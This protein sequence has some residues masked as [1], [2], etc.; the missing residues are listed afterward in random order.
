[1]GTEAVRHLMTQP[2]RYDVFKGARFSMELQ[3]PE[4]DRRITIKRTDQ[5]AQ[6]SL[7][8]ESCARP[9]G[10]TKTRL[11]LGT[12]GTPPVFSLEEQERE[13]M[14][15]VPPT[16]TVTAYDGTGELYAVTYFLPESKGHEGNCGRPDG[17]GYRLPRGKPHGASME[18]GNAAMIGYYSFSE[19]PARIDCGATERAF[20]EADRFRQ[21]RKSAPYSSCFQPP[22]VKRFL[23]Y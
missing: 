19:L 5:C 12:P 11:E 18:T 14:P 17:G 22:S 16:V 20:P 6:I 23:A 2:P 4:S 9:F 10:A 15:C 8:E 7:W 13:G 1:M 21:L 3:D